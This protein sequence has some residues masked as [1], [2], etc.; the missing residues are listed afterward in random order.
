MRILSGLLGTLFVS[1]IFVAT[2]ALAAKIGQLAN[3][4]LDVRL[5]PAVCVQVNG[6]PYKQGGRV[7]I[8]ESRDGWVRVS[9]YLNAEELKA[10]FGENVPEKPALW[11]PVSLLAGNN[12]DLQAT[13]ATTE[14]KQ[15]D[16]IASEAKDK[17][18]PVEKVVSNQRKVTLP[19]FRPG[20]TYTKVA[21]LDT[22][23]KPTPA[24]TEV[25]K[26]AEKMEKQ[27]EAKDEPATETEVAKAE[28]EEVKPSA[29]VMSAETAETAKDSAE[30]VAKAATDENVVEEK[31][32]VEKKKPIYQA[33]KAEETESKPTP[34]E[35]SKPTVV[36][37][38]EEAAE[39]N[40]ENQAV[41]TAKP[42]PNPEAEPESKANAQVASTEPTF[43]SDG[44]QPLITEER[45][46]K[47]IKA[48]KE[49][50]L[51]KLPSSKTK[52]YKLD[53][54]IAIRHHALM[55]LK[56]Q[57]CK[58][59]LDGGRSLSQ[60]GWLYVICSDDPT[61]LRQFPLQESTW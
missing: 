28:P 46:K 33:P 8:F 45:P 26:S 55:L 7:R 54:I 31:P 61:Y 34:S 43:S 17:A 37:K 49:K 11:V 48:L 9:N 39:S 58:G 16:P 41:E 24:P 23:E 2:S 5:C 40:S 6:H 44:A 50:R 59:I 18:K 36:A 35:T 60:K 51:S 57:E 3:G 47:Y 56:N 38:I 22:D 29:E 14:V 27:V 42:E 15:D 10:K 25:A 1:A 19:K 13:P 12:G 32:Q 30:K 21:A 20:T 53:E 4:P 52:G